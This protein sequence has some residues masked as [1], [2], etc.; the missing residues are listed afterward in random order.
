VEDPRVERTRK[1]HL[2]D[3]LFISLC[4]VICGCES[5]EDMEEFGNAK[6]SGSASILICPTRGLAMNLVRRESTNRRGIKGRV[7]R[8]GWDNKYLEKILTK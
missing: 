3:I 8:A 1:H 4:A 2:S 6:K 7:K 5:F